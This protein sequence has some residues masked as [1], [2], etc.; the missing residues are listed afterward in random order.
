MYWASFIFEY[1]FSRCSAVFTQFFPVRSSHLSFTKREQSRLDPAGTVQKVRGS[2]TSW[3]I[4][5]HALFMHLSL[6]GKPSVR[7]FFVSLVNT[8]V[9]RA[10]INIGNLESLSI[11]FNSLC[12]PDGS[13]WIET[14]IWFCSFC[15]AHKLVLDFLQGSFAS[16]WSSYA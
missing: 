9:A 6:L 15:S 5:V 13:F 10:A 3:D 4:Y 7:C 11:D 8:W 12:V 2:G 14:C 1:L 16:I